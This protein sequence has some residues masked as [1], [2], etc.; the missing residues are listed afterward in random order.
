MVIQAGAARQVL[1]TDPNEA[2]AA[3][4]AVEAAGRDTMTELRHLLGRAGAADGHGAGR[5]RRREWSH[6]SRA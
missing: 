1:A 6:R 5:S 3:L 4:L 2:A